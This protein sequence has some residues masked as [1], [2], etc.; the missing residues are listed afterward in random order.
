MSEKE[1]SGEVTV[2]I[3]KDSENEELKRK[4]KAQ[5]D[6]NKKLAEEAEDYKE[7]LALEE[8]VKNEKR[9]QFLTEK[10][11]TLL[12]KT[13]LTKE[14]FEEKIKTSEGLREVADIFRIAERA[15][16]KAKPE[17][18]KVSAG[19][20]PLNAAQGYGQGGNEDIYTK[21][22]ESYED[23]IKALRTESHS[24]DP[25]RARK[26]SMVLNELLNK[27]ARGQKENK[28]EN[29]YSEDTNVPKTDKTPDL[30]MDNLAD[31]PYSELE[32]FGIK[33]SPLG[34][35]KRNQRQIIV[36]KGTQ[37]EEKEGTKE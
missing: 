28:S 14:Q 29:V 4:L 19:S 16:E 9:R 22:F 31:E 23:M 32:R 7:K 5:E 21:K 35:S 36:Q 10:S 3:E 2:K 18:K 34:Y 27:Y 37:K 25:A 26:A 24:D 6:A 12:D 1:N 17:E 15:I 33:K 13:D 30:V 8:E 11:Q 20:A